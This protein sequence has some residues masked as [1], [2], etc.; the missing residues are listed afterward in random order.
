M[1]KYLEQSSKLDSENSPRLY[2]YYQINVGQ[3]LKLVIYSICMPWSPYFFFSEHYL[4][5]LSVI[6]FN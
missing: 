2:F 6:V 5:S 1:E 4:K 3:N